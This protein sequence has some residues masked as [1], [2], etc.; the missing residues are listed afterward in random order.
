MTSLLN[1]SRAFFFG[2]KKSEIESIAEELSVITEHKPVATTVL[3]VNY[4]TNMTALYKAI[5]ESDWDA[6]L[7][8][9]KANPDEART[10]VVRKSSE[11]PNKNIWRFLPI[12]SA[13]AR[14]PP[15]TLIQELIAAYPVGARCV[16]DQ[17]MYALHYAAGNQAKR[18]V[19]RSL[20]T[21]YPEATKCADPRGMLPIHY[22]ACWGPSSIS[23]VDMVMVANSDISDAKDED[24]NTPMDLAKSADYPERN[25]VVYALKRWENASTTADQPTLLTSPKS[26]QMN[27]GSVGYKVVGSKFQ[28]LTLGDERSVMLGEEKDSE[29]QSVV[30]IDG[31]PTCLSPRTAEKEI[32]R[33]DDQISVMEFEKKE[34]I[35]KMSEMRLQMKEKDAMIEKLQKELATVREECIGLRKTLV[36]VTEKVTN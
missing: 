14:Q 16:D 28:S 1:S 3:E 30:I 6:A 18:D 19:M 2:N 27:L 17:G 21:A 7:A 9:L 26:S 31:I 36:D 8:A 34:D 20:L 13:C 10:W 5:T 24:G 33:M 11:N 35:M 25:A 29:D 4:D 32:H 22:L 12:H 23:V 15:N